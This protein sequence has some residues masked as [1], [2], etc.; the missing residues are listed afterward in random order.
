ML[1]IMNAID[2]KPYLTVREAEN[3][4]LGLDDGDWDFWQLNSIVMDET[5]E[6]LEDDS[7]M[8]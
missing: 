7:W 5:L 2:S 3:I 8:D 1:A 4:Q 6:S